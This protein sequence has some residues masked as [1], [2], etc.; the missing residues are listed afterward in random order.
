MADQS[1][2]GIELKI[3]QAGVVICSGITEKS[4]DYKRD[5]VDIT[6][7]DD[8]GYETYAPFS[9][10]KAL[11]I[12]LSGVLKNDKMRQ[13]ALQTNPILNNL[14]VLYP[15]GATLVGNF[16]LEGLKEEYKGLDAAKYS[17]TLKTSGAYIYTPAP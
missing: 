15:D 5:L 16:V 2:Q 8:S 6:S 13:L 1:R 14:T 3:K 10:V 4:I 7:D 9:G 11:S 12:P 17:F